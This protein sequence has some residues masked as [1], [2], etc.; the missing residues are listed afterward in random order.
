[1]AELDEKSDEN[2]V[3]NFELSEDFTNFDL[4]QFNE[5]ERRHLERQWNAFVG[6]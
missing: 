1:M 2:E 6:E 3:S 5:N 4:V